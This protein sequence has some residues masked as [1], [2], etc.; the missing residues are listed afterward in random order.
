VPVDQPGQPVPP[1][2]RGAQAQHITAV[3][4]RHRFGEGPGRGAVALIHH[5]EADMRRRLG[6]ALG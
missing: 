2:G 1:P 3:K 5:Q 4:R 6:G